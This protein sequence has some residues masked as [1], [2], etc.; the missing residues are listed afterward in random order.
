MKRVALFYVFRN[1]FS[2]WIQPV[3]AHYFSRSTWRSSGLTKT[4][5]WER[6][7]TAGNVPGG[8]A[9][10]P[11]VVL[12][13][14]RLQCGNW[15]RVSGFSLF[16][17]LKASGLTCPLSDSLTAHSFLTA[18]VSLVGKYRLT[19]LC[20][21]PRCWCVSLYNVHKW[22]LCEVP[23]VSSERWVRKLSCSDLVVDVFPKIHISRK[24]SDFLLDK[25]Y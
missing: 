11:H 10:S 25:K 19:D 2:V 22:H 16:V 18:C 13:S 23:L 1:L 15:N 7:Q 9:T 3:V 21:C 12:R 8:E 4:H 20:R 17:T 6:A 14:C 24:W 5:P